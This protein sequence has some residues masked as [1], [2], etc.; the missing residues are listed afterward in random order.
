MK[1][2]AFSTQ[3]PR[4]EPIPLTKY[5]RIIQSAE[6]PFYYLSDNRAWIIP[7][8]HRMKTDAGSIP[9]IIQW[10]PSLDAERFA[11]SYYCHDSLFWYRQALRRKEWRD[12]L[13]DHERHILIE[14]LFEPYDRLRAHLWMMAF[15]VVQVGL[16]WSNDMLDEM[17]S[18]QTNGNARLSRAA[19]RAGVFAGSWVPWLVYR[20]RQR[21][22]DY[23]GMPPQ[24]QEVTA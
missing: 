19:I 18:A 20:R 7:V 9:H 3:S 15:D 11:A 1:L 5:R 16:H 6:N 12:A 13:T 23:D 10:I 21:S 22:A 4:S 24:A 14:G 17:I 2:G 8:P